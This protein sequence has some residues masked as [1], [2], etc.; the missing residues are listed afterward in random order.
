MRLK[1]VNNPCTPL[2]FSPSTPSVTLIKNQLNAV[3]LPV[4]RDGANNTKR[5]HFRVV[6]FVARSKSQRYLGSTEL[7]SL[8][9]IGLKTIE[10]D[11]KESKKQDEYGNSSVIELR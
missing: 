11:Y 9:S 4:T 3:G 2:R 5:Q 10:L 1:L 6:A 8:Q 7:I